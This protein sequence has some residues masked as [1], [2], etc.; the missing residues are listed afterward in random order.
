MK[1]TLGVYFCIEH[2][3]YKAWDSPFKEAC[4]C[5]C[6]HLLRRGLVLW[7]PTFTSSWLHKTKWSMQ[8]FFIRL[9]KSYMFAQLENYTYSSWVTTTKLFLFFLI[10]FFIMLSWISNKMQHSKLFLYMY[11]YLFGRLQQNWIK[12]KLAKKVSDINLNPT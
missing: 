8:F 7:H 10:F 9:L 1:H 6:Q 12:K 4:S 5:K 3:A 11:E 2:I